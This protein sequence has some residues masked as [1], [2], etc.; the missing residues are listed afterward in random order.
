MML[1]GEVY[2]QTVVRSL[3]LEVDPSEVTGS[4][5]IVDRVFSFCFVSTTKA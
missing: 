1:E 3:F 4:P 2:L 5:H